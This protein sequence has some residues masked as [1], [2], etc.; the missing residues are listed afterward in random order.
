MI[1][2][3]LPVRSRST[4]ARSLVRFRTGRSRKPRELARA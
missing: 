2:Q 3:R 4:E 1:V